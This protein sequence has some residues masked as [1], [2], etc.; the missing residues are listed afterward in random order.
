MPADRPPRTPSTPRANGKPY[1]VPPDCAD[2]GTPLVCVG[3]ANGWHDEFGCPK[4]K[5]GIV[6]DVPPREYDAKTETP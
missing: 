5:D 6:L 3:A 1:Y 2:C 4:C